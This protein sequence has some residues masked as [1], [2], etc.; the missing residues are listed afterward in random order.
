MAEDAHEAQV[1]AHARSDF[2]RREVCAYAVSYGVPAAAAW[3][4]VTT[5]A[6]YEWMHRLGTPVN[7]TVIPQAIVASA[8]PHVACPYCVLG[9]P[10]VSGNPGRQADRDQALTAHILEEHVGRR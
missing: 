9:A 3:A 1:A 4:G 6:V 8:F 7:G 10:L 2:D 5:S